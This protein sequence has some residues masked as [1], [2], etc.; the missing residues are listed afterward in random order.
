MFLPRLAE[1]TVRTALGRQAA[2]ALIGRR[3]VGKPT[4]ARDIGDQVAAHYLDLEDREDRERLSSP[5]LYPDG[6]LWAI[7]IKRGLAAKPRRGF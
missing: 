5:R 6:A 3:Q 1:Q 7:E 2:L 4:L